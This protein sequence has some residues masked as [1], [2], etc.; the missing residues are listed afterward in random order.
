MKIIIKESH[1]NFILE[2]LEKNKKFLNKI[3]D[4]L[5]KHTDNNKNDYQAF[6]LELWNITVFERRYTC[7]ECACLGSLHI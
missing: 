7:N 4:I 5:H 2:N 6:K 3:M 1:Y